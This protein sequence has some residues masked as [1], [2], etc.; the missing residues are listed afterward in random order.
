[1]RHYPCRLI[2]GA[3]ALLGG[4]VGLNQTNMEAADPPLTS[5]FKSLVEQDA[6]NALEMIDRINMQMTGTKERKITEKRAA[7]SIPANAIMIAAYAQNRITGKNAAEDARMATLR[8]AALKVVRS[9]G[10]KQFAMAAADLQKLKADMPA[11]AN[12]NP[13]IVNLAAEIDTETLMHQFKKTATGGLGIEDEIKDLADPMNKTPV[14]P[15]K[16][17]ALAERLLTVADMVDSLTP[18]GGFNAKKNKKAWDGFNKDMRTAA[19]NLIT[20]ANA[21][22]PDWK[23]AFAKLDASCVACHQIMK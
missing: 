7:S 5:E 11:D 14:N 6:K 10:A 2:V 18:Q 3:A 4:I 9:A 8:D 16:A 23:G 13:K 20:T 15:A 21:K 1:M 17:I 22:N 12:A 19:K